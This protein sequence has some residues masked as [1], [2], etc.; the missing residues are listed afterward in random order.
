MSKI[1]PLARRADIVLQEFGNEILIY[2]LRANK[3]FNLNETSSLIWQLLNGDKT[4]SEIANDLTQKFNSPVTEEFVWLALDQLRKDKLIENEAEISGLYEGVSRRELIK[5]A[6]LASVVTLPLVFSLIAPSAV[7]AQSGSC[8]ATPFPIGCSCAANANCVN[9]CCGTTPSG[10]T[11]VTIGLE[12]PGSGCR[13]N[14]ECASNSCPPAAPA[15]PRVC[16]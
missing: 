8:V 14:C 2:D 13:T 7:T 5:R 10:N 6:G 3:A 9:N 11:C 12:P 1:K 4:I 15:T 16:A